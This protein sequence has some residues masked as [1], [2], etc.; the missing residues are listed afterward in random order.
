VCLTSYLPTLTHDLTDLQPSG[1]SPQ[2]SGTGASPL[3]TLEGDRF[4]SQSCDGDKWDG[5][6]ICELGS[7]RERVVIDVG[8]ISWYGRIFL[9]GNGMKGLFIEGQ[10]WLGVDLRKGLVA[11]L[12][13]AADCLGCS[14]LFVLLRNPL[15][16]TCNPPLKWIVLTGSISSAGLTAVGISVGSSFGVS[17]HQRDGNIIRPFDINIYSHDIISLW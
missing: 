12:D 4:Q 9:E 3:P 11:I 10:H 5:I 7:L 8:G 1:A 17:E 2:S 14:Q 16:E 13:L 15:V 6:E